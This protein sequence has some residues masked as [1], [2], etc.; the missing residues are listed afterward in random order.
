MLI[1]LYARKEPTT[2]PILKS[3]GEDK[4][5]DTV[6]YAD[7]ACTQLKARFSW[8]FS[9]MP[10]RGQKLVTLNCFRWHLEWV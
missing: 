10:R 1:T 6:I 3:H 2:D 9:G 8:L 7:R 5:Q 4:R